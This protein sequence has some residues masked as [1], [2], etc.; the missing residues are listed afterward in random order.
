MQNT[1]YTQLY[2]APL[3]LCQKISIINIKKNRYKSAKMT[4]AFWC[5]HRQWLLSIHELDLY[6]NVPGRCQSSIAKVKPLR[7]DKQQV[8]ANETGIEQTLVDE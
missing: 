1:F 5:T 8:S 7:I 4:Y 3:F 6:G 2:H